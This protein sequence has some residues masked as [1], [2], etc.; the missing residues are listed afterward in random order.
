MKRFFF[1]RVSFLAFVCVFATLTPAWGG[2]QGTAHPVSTRGPKAALH[3]LA[4]DGGMV[5][6]DTD[7]CPVCGMLPTKQ[8]KF[9]AAMM[10]SDGRTFYFC[11]N[12]C[13]LRTFK[14][15]DTYLKKPADQIERMVVKNYFN[16]TPMDAAAAWWVAGSDVVG[17]MGPALVA[18][19]D[20]AEVVQFKSR[21]GG[22]IVFRL[23]EV[24]DALWVRLFPQNKK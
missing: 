7:R 12:G 18:L 4:E 9:A 16:G 2:S 6:S 10:L 14:H 23:S 17:P 8:P 20:E 15:A 13:L 24:D 19:A 11:G 5:I 21:H 1:T 3:A 22:K